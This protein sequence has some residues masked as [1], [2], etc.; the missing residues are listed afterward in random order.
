[1]KKN[2]I[3]TV[4]IL[5]AVAG[6]SAAALYKAPEEAKVVNTQARTATVQQSQPESKPV[7]AAEAVEDSAVNAPVEAAPT[8]TETLSVLSTQEYAEKY[9]NL[10]GNNQMCFDSIVAAFP[11][12]FTESERE[13][14][15]KALTIFSSPCSSGITEANKRGVIYSFGMNGEFFDSEAAKSMH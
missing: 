9:L 4:T 2:I 15:V 5:A 10:L 3:I 7:T 11:D 8:P 12:R 6:S 14:N 1:M 13:K